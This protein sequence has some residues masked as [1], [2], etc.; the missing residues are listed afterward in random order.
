MSPS[1]NQGWAFSSWSYRTPLKAISVSWGNDTGDGVG[2]GY[3]L[4]QPTCAIWPC[5]G[6]ILDGPFPSYHGLMVGPFNFMT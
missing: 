2:S 6:L 4:K 1:I 3:L 5:I